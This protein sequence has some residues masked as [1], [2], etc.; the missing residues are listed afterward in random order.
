MEIDK[1]KLTKNKIS[2]ANL[3][4]QQI[5]RTYILEDLRK[6]KIEIE[7]EEKEENN[8]DNNLKDKVNY[9]LKNKNENIQENKIL[10]EE[11]QT[12]NE[13]KF[14][15]QNGKK[16]TDKIINPS[17]FWLKE[18]K[19]NYS[20]KVQFVKIFYFSILIII[21]ISLILG[22]LLKKR[23]KY[24]KQNN[25][26]IRENIDIFQPNINLF[27]PYIFNYHNG[28]IKTL[29]FKGIVQ[30]TNYVLKKGNSIT[31]FPNVGNYRYYT[32][33]PKEFR[34]KILRELHLNEQNKM[35]KNQNLY[36]VPYDIDDKWIFSLSKCITSQ[37]QKINRFLN[38]KEYVSKSLLYL[39]YKKMKDIFPHEYDFML[40]TYSYPEDK[41]TI[42]NIFKNYSLKN[43]SR[44]NIWLIKPKLS[45]VGEG[46]KILKSFEN[47]KNID[48]NIFITRL[49]NNPNLI[50]G[51]KYD[52]RFHGLVS[53]IKPLKLYLY[54][55]GFVRLSTEKYEFNNFT[56]KFSFLTNMGINKKSKKYIYPN[57]T[58][59]I[60]NSNLWNL[61]ILKNYFLKNNLDYNKLFDEIK[62]IFI[63][64]IFSVR[65]KL[66]KKINQVN[67]SSKNF[68][69]LIGFDILLD[70]N[71]KPYLLET[72]RRGGMRDNNAAEI[73]YTHNI[74][75]DTL[76]LVG[77]RPIDQNNNDKNI[78]IE[79]DISELERPRGMYN[80]IFPLKNNIEKYK[81]FY[82]NNIPS[83]DLE[84]W[85][86]LK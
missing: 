83:E 33:T 61:S 8:E 18:N 48:K 40:E 73:G 65:E 26:Y 84:L 4:E 70:E 72:N 22:L 49:L 36:I 69:H 53:S 45:S 27:K 50:R 30:S 9:N 29:L 24:F 47:I 5:E 12:E 31:S 85:K 25:H 82:L 11:Q 68:Y 13:D 86:F 58:K 74:I 80:L 66:I 34:E 16:N 78:N 23:L 54:D 76:N 38:Y 42:F 6:K 44:D 14:F 41:D 81:K 43:S 32:E 35:K 51:Y 57:K 21:V 15:K 71:L 64:I 39:N 77:L 55:E 56:N 2:L 28:N 67:L 37:Y 1:K 60:E 62:D 19:N 46:I 75:I 17:T 20:K 52:I 3:D 10:I 7:K 59:D 63:K 79:D